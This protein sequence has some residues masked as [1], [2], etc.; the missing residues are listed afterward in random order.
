MIGMPELASIIERAS[1]LLGDI[2]PRDREARQ[3][4]LFR[5]TGCDESKLRSKEGFSMLYNVSDKDDALIDWNALNKDFYH[6]AETEN[7]GFEAAADGYTATNKL[8]GS[9]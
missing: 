4:A 5:I 7:G 6:L 1:S 9:K 8:S 2:Y 3:L